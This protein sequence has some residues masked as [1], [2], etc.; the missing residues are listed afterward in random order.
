MLYSNRKLKIPNSFK[1]TMFGQHKM[2]YE[3]GVFDGEK[4]S[5]IYFY[6][7]A[8]VDRN[9]K[10]NKYLNSVNLKPFAVDPSDFGEKFYPSEPDRDAV[11]SVMK[12]VAQQNSQNLKRN[13]DTFLSTVSHDNDKLLW[14]GGQR[15]Q[16]DKFAL[17]Y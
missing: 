3:G 10:I 11:V 12:K 16:N 7:P 1:T 5:N 2:Q 13:A 9:E 6:L 15:T 14:P 17:T 8:T 4:C